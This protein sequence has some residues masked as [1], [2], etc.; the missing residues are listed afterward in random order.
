MYAVFVT[1][2]LQDATLSVKIASNM[3]EREIFNVGSRE[4]LVG[5]ATPAFVSRGGLLQVF[6]Y[7]PSSC[8]ISDI[9]TLLQ[10]D[11]DENV[12][13]TVLV[14]IHADND[15]SFVD[16]NVTFTMYKIGESPGGE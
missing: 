6:L 5:C 9:L 14:E 13:E 3:L 11:D 8:L 7:S 4:G 12:A 15:E 2:I 16:K 10:I 1:A